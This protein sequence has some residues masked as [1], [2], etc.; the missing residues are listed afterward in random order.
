[1]QRTVFLIINLDFTGEEVFS[2]AELDEKK[3]LDI[4]AQFGNHLGEA[5]KMILYTIDPEV[6]VLGGSVSKSFKYFETSMWNSVNKFSYSHSLEKLKIV[7]SALNYSAILGA[8]A[9]Y[10]E[11]SKNNYT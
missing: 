2:R 5:I 4:F 3:A 7:V 9:L 1:L 6:I 10:Y 8:A 11:A